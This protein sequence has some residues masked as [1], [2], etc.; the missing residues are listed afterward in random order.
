MEQGE[1]SRCSVG[2]NSGAGATQASTYSLILCCKAGY[3]H[4]PGS[5]PLFRVQA[6]QVA[7]MDRAQ[8]LLHPN[9]E[10]TCL[11]L[12]LRAASPSWSGQ[13][14]RNKVP[15]PFHLHPLTHS[16]SSSGTKLYYADGLRMGGSHSQQKQ[17]PWTL[18]PAEATQSVLDWILFHVKV[19][20]G[21]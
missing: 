16:N 14:N 17:S 21:L 9:Q 11:F 4:L 18:S 5:L 3:S 8:H 13:S 20:L 2:G 15:T 19:F 1:R 6:A 10:A 12:C 7:T